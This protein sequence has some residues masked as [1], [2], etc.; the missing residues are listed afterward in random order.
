MAL[1]EQNRMLQ[2]L[3][4]KG[5]DRKHI[6]TIMEDLKESGIFAE[7]EVED[8][9]DW[10]LVDQKAKIWFSDLDPQEKLEAIKNITVEREIET[11]KYKNQFYYDTEKRIQVKIREMTEKNLRGVDDESEEEDVFDIPVTTRYGRSPLHEAIAMRDIR[12]IKRYVKEG[13]YLTCVDN[14]DHTPMEMAYYEGYTKAMAVF[15]A[16]QSKK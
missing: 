2:I 12:L 9:I 16:H 6:K 10:E 15:N 11:S 1:H 8:E 3:H 7:E 14:N 5:V 4:K 13:L